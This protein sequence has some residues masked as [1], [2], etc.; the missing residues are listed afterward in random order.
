MKLLQQFVDEHC[1]EMV[2]NGVR[3]LVNGNIERIPSGPRDGLKRMV[4]LHRHLWRHG[5]MQVLR[6]THVTME[7]WGYRAM[8]HIIAHELTTVAWCGLIAD[9][10]IQPQPAPDTHSL[11]VLWRPRRNCIHRH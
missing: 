8:K 4:R 2:Q 3:L 9:G 11:L 6:T 7:G 10:G 1:Q 5:G